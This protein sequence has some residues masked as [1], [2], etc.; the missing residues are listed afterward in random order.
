MAAFPMGDLAVVLQA[1]RPVRGASHCPAPRRMPDPAVEAVVRGPVQAL[2][3]EILARLALD[4]GARDLVAGL[5]AC[6]TARSVG[7]D[8][9]R[10][11]ELQRSVEAA[12]ECIALRHTAGWPARDVR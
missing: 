9:V 6:I 10:T 8:D 3:E 1:R 12:L 11:A 2:P 5:I 4:A 7:Y